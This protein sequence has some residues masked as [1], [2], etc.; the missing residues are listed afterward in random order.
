MG[1]SLSSGLSRGI[2]LLLTIASA[3]YLSF[4]ANRY[5]RAG[6]GL[7][8]SSLVHHAFRCDPYFSLTRSS[9]ICGR[10]CQLA[11][12]GYSFARCYEMR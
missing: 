8:S 4:L 7:L 3:S 12:D 10:Y 6:G 1:I 2:L 5:V 11:S 9:A